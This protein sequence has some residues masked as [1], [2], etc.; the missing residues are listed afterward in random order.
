MA[1]DETK[2][3]VEN[4]T[5]AAT[6]A[7]IDPKVTSMFDTYIKQSIANGNGNANKGAVYTAQDADAA[8]QNIWQQLYGKNAMGADYAKAV[9]LYINQ[10]QDTGE[11]GRTQA[12]VD[13]AQSTQEFQGMQEDK[14]LDAIYTTIQNNVRKAQV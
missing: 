4:P 7:G 5:P 1:K 3:K 14:Y 9:S 2:P 11:P 8:V 12:V 13:Y 10:S 6:S